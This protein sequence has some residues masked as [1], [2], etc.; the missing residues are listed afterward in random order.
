MDLQREASVTGRTNRQ[1]AGAAGRPPHWSSTS[2][3]TRFAFVRTRSETWPSARVNL[4]AFCSRLVTALAQPPQAALE[5]GAGVAANVSSGRPSRRSS[6]ALA[7]S[8]R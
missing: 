2:M 4:N 1:A 8:C 6:L 7:L 5:H 3:R